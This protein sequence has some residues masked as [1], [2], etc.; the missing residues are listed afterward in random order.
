[1]FLLPKPGFCR[2]RGSQHNIW[3]ESV[4]ACSF[5]ALQ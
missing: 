1:M 5:D 4:E 2:S 3:N